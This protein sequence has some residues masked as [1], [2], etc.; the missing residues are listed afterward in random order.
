ML[1]MHVFAVFFFFGGLLLIR[2]DSNFWAAVL[3]NFA[4]TSSGA[5]VGRHGGQVGDREAS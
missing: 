2:F 4:N 1:F 3:S 5:N